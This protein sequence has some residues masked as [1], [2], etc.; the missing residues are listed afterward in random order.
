[1]GEVSSALAEEWLPAVTSHREAGW[2]EAAR[3]VKDVERTELP[4][5]LLAGFYREQELYGRRNVKFKVYSELTSS[6]LIYFLA[7]QRKQ[8]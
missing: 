3:E 4:A 2:M 1:M 8:Q 7:C 6:K 5:S